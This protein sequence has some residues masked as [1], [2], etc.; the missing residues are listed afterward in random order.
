MATR[1]G[2]RKAAEASD[3]SSDDDGGMADPAFMLLP[4]KEK[5]SEA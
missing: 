2:A 1:E 4:E 5:R 3:D